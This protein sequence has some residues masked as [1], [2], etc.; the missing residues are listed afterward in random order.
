MLADDVKEFKDLTLQKIG[1]QGL[2]VIDTG[3]TIPLLE[4]ERKRIENR[5]IVG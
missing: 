4:K 3:E 1:D 2:P 5:E